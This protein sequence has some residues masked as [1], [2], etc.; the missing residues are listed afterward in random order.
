MMKVGLIITLQHFW[1]S[2]VKFSRKQIGLNSLSAINSRPEQC[3]DGGC[4]ARIPP[5]SV[6]ALAGVT[7]GVR[8]NARGVRSKELPP[9]CALK[10]TPALTGVR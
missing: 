5:L 4:G 6:V 3:S 1:G 2:S 8:F 7:P 9:D 10:R